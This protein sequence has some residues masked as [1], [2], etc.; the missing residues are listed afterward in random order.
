MSKMRDKK[1]GG[2]IRGQQAEV[3]CVTLGKSLSVS[4]LSCSSI[5]GEAGQVDFDS[6]S[7]SSY[8]VLGW[9]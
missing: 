3:G 5:K 1:K 7:Q 9:R 6:S 8:V 4:S 2:N